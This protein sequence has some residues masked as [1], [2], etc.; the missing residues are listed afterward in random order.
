ML[1]RVCRRSR[2][3]GDT[4]LPEHVLDVPGDGVLA[5]DQ[6]RCD[7]TVRP[8]RSHEPEHLELARRQ[9]V[10]GRCLLGPREHVDPRLL[11]LI[12]REIDVTTTLAHV[13]AEDLADSLEV[14]RTTDV[15]NIVLDKVIGL[16]ELLDEGIVPL[17]QK[18]RAKG[19]IVVDV[20][21]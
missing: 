9:T 6:L 1:E 12:V 20:T 10:R 4:E 5:D 21:R 2:P 18:K 17:A 13:L 3:R 15:F 16:D 7:L 8:P 11:S 14:L 19:K